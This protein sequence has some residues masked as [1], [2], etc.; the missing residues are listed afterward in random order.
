MRK[1]Y[2]S[3]RRNNAQALRQSLE[4][5]RHQLSLSRKLQHK[6][7]LNTSLFSESSK[8]YSSGMDSPTRTMDRIE[9][10]REKKRAT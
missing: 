7:S 6:A 9:R 4:S 10:L 8:D 5:D 3:P 2:I 1:H